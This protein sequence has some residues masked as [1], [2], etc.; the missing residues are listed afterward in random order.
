MK[1]GRVESWGRVGETALLA[2]VFLAPLAVSGRTYDPGALR[3]A[4]LESCALVLA[5]AWLL[6]GLARG[7]WEAAG[8]SSRTLGP[9]AALALWTLARFALAPFKGAALPALVIE[10]STWIVYAVALLELGGARSASRLAFWTAAASALAAACAAFAPRLVAGMG[11]EQ[12]A[13]FCAVA[14]PV[15]LSLRLDPEASAARRLFSAGAAA[16]LALL[17]ARCGSGRGLAAFA[18]SALAFALASVVVLRGRAGNRGALLALACAALA[19]AAAALLGA[20]STGGAP[21]GAFDGL[22][23]VGGG[24]LA[25]TA[26]AA[27][28][29]GLTA[30]SRLRARGALAESGYAAAFSSAF[31]AWAISVLLGLAPRS[32][33]G[34][35][36]AWAAGGIAAGL[37]PLARPRGTALAL[38][39]PYGEDVRRLLQ[40]PVLALFFVLL[41]WP[42]GWLA[43]DVLYNRALAEAR[44]GRLDAALVDAGRV[45]PG[46]ATRPA[47]LYLRGRVLLD[48]GKPREALA[49]FAALDQVAPDFSRVHARRAEAYAS[50]GDWRAAM[51]ERSRQDARTPRDVQNLAAWAG[52][53]RA[54]GDMSEARRAA[55]RAEA[56]AP[57]DTAVQA[58]LAANGLMERKLGEAEAARRRASRK[59]LALKPK[60]R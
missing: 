15:V 39:L 50:L 24:L 22:G 28:A 41:A 42:S 46:S 54:A 11:P 9:L 1:P 12:I 17:A 2:L 16:A 21:A 59:R 38:P 44:G 40:G 33:A 37:A 47:A 60:T 52:A 6:K 13:A 48:E 30:A 34:A 18:V 43:S 10:V 8:E 53:A 58:Q 14:L 45:W 57:G 5:A 26:A 35:W 32:G 31:G 19:F 29:A 55:S 25:W 7:R 56:L 49:A 36:L 27:A 4:L 20:T 3:T 23:L 51:M